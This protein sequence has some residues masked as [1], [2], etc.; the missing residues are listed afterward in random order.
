M[1][2]TDEVSQEHNTFFGR[3][4]K[5]Q[6][7]EANPKEMTLALMFLLQILAVHVDGPNRAGIIGAI[8]RII[9]PAL[10][11]IV[12]REDGAKDLII[13]NFNV[14]HKICVPVLL[15]GHDII[16]HTVSPLIR[17]NSAKGE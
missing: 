17:E 3:I 14:V 11:H 5:E 16:A 8:T 7:V 13:R 12:I 6:A 9:D 2:I 4:P 15:V 10:V 1:E